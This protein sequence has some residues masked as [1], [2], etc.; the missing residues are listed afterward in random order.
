[1]GERGANRV[2]TSFS[3][4]LHICKI[5]SIVIPTIPIYNSKTTSENAHRQWRRETD[6]KRVIGFSSFNVVDIFD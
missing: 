6:E 4:M 2:K 1:M 3:S 5:Y